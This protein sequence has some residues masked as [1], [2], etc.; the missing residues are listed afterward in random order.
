M[1]TTHFKRDWVNR[2]AN[3]GEKS[4]ISPRYIRNHGAIKLSRISKHNEISVR[5]ARFSISGEAQ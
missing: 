1:A 4:K 2:A 3:R 5:A